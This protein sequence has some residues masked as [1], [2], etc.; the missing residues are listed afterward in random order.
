MNRRQPDYRSYLLRLWW[1]SD[2]GTQTL[3]IY[4]ENPFTGERR[5]FSSLDELNVF[6]R[7]EAGLDE[8]D[9]H[10]EDKVDD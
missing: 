2:E 9:L 6:L 8:G 7:E 1:A 4:I 10:G 3:R 5:G